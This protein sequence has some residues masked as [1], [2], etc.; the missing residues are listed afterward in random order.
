M[1]ALAGALRLADAREAGE[2]R[3]RARWSLESLAA[4]GSEAG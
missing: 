1:I 2:I 3:A 4:P